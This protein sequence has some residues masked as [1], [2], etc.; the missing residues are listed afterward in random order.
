MD[1]LPLLDQASK[2]QWRRRA[3]DIERQQGHFVVDLLLNGQPVQ[4]HE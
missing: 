4:L 2:V 3:V 1:V